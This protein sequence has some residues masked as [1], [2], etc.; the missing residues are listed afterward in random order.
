MPLRGTWVPAESTLIL[1]FSP[2][3]RI[4]LSSTPWAIGDRQMLAEQTINTVIF[5][6]NN[7]SIFYDQRFR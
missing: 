6:L 2:R 1:F 5:F 3:S 7:P 4:M